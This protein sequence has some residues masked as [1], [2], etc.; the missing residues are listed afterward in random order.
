MGV[1]PPLD[2]L[3]GSFVS[4]WLQLCLASAPVLPS[5]G[6]LPSEAPTAE[7]P[8]RALVADR[9]D[10]TESPVTVEPGHVQLEVS[11]VD[12]TRDRRDDSLS[13]VQANLKFGL[14]SSTDLQVVFESYT[15]QNNVRGAEDEGFGDVQL[16][17]KWNLF[18][19]DGGERALGVM[20]Y[21]KVPTDTELSNGEW[22]GGIIVPYALALDDGLGLGL[23]A[24]LDWV[25]DG[26]G[27]HDLEFLH[28]AALGIDVD[29]RLGAFVEYAGVAREGPDTAL[30]GLGATY[31][32]H[33]DLMLDAGVRLGL[34]DEADDLGV[35][36]G[37]TARH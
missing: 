13:A 30:L 19:N 1:L 18:G 2:S 37:F 12:W 32:V 33:Q 22:E 6:P 8:H 9:P 3:L 11:L 31:L 4:L 20:P 36:L 25:A 7:R 15:W 29:E 26:D 14:T 35:F 17:L 5:D 21:I 23:M 27:G 16:R 24:E 34:N 10:I 28:S